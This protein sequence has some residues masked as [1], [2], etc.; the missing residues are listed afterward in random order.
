MIVPYSLTCLSPEL[1]D[2][3]PRI[4]SSC[5]FRRDNK[6]NPSFAHRVCILVMLSIVSI[7]LHELGHYTAYK[8]AN[9]PVHVTFQ[10]VRP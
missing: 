10:S 9:I 6:V 4:F 5:S 7:P 1:S 8:I 2:R 3:T